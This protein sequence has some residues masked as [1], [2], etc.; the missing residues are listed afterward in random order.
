MEQHV[1]PETLN[2]SEDVLDIL[3]QELE[4]LQNSMESH[5]HNN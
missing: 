5:T 2:Q 1:E 4:N 3:D